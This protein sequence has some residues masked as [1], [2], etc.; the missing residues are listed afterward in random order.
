MYTGLPAKSVKK[1]ALST[2]LKIM[3]TGL[4]AKLVRTIGHSDKVHSGI[5]AR[6]ERMKHFVGDVN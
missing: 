6:S 5:D 1:S 3:Y 4:P 2:K